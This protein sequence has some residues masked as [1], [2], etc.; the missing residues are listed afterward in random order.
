MSNLISNLDLTKITYAAFAAGDVPVVLA[1]MDAGIEWHEPD[2][3]IY[4]E[5]FADPI[6]YSTIFS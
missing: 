3:F 1:S 4:P 2:G 6:A 5:T